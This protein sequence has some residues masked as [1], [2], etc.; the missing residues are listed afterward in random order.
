[1]LTI[2]MR[3]WGTSHSSSTVWVPLGQLEQETGVA[4]DYYDD[5]HVDGDGESH[6]DD[7]NDGDEDDDTKDGD[8]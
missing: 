6:D 4:G 5:D 1:M 3:V 7:D 2:F 8:G